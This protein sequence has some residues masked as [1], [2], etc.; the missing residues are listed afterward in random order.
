M[1]RIHR[2]GQKRPVKVVKIVIENSIED[3][4]V[5]LQAKKLAMTEAALSSDSDSALGKLT[6][7]DVSLGFLRDVCG[8]N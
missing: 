4:I 6:V 3:Q 8:E 7:E 2:L 1:D 5:Q